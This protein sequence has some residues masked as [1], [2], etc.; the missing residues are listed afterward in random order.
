[1]NTNKIF[2][3]WNIGQINI[4][5]CSD[6]YRIHATLEECRRANLDVVCLQ[7]VRRLNTGAIKH[8]GYSF[9]WNGLKRL[10]KHGVAIA[11]RNSKD[12]VLNGVIYFSAR[13]MAAD[14]TVKGCRIRVVSCYAPTLN[15]SLAAKQQFYRDLKR[16][17]KVEK[18]RKLMVMGDF[19]AEPHFC[20]EHSC[21]DGRNNNI[22]AS[23]NH[24]N[25]NTM[26]FLQFCQNAK[27]SI[28]NTWFDHPIHHRITW[29]HPNSA[30]PGRVI[31]YS[32][33]ESWIRQFVTNVRVKNSYFN[34]D[35]KLLI[36]KMNTP[37]NKAA[38]RFLRKPKLKRRNIAALKCETISANVQN[39][40]QDHILNQPRTSSTLDG[41]HSYIIDSLAAGQTLIPTHPRH[42]SQVI[43]WNQD[44]QL[45]EL[46]KIRIDLRK[47][48]TTLHDRE[49]LKQINKSIK[50]RV[51]ELQNKELTEKGRNINEARQHRNMVKMWRNAKKHDAS[52]YSKAQTIPC[53]GLSEHFQQHFNPDHSTLAVPDEI[54]ET[55]QYIRILQNSNIE[56][57]DQTPSEEEITQAIK[58]LNNGKAA[59]DI[60][61]ELIKLAAGIPGFIAELHLYFTRIWT[62]KQV[63]KQWAISRICAIWKNKGSMT[64]P[65]KY[66]GISIGSTLCKVAMNIILKR[67]SDF[68]EQQLMRTQFGFR[69]GMGCNDGIYMLKQMQEVAETSDKKLYVCFVDL[70]AAFDHVNRDML[71]KTIKS[72]IHSNQNNANIQI[73]ENLYQVTKSYLQHEDPDC[74]FSTSSG[75]RQGGQEGPW[76][77]NFYHDFALRVYEDRKTANGIPGLEIPFYIPNEATNR[78]QRSESPQTGIVDDDH[79]GYADDSAFITWSANDL[80]L[81]MNILHQVFSE[82]G[83]T[84]NLEKTETMIFNW[85]PSVDGVYPNSIITLNNQNI[86]NSTSFKYLGVW[87]TGNCLHIG[88]QELNHRIDSAHCAFAQSRKLLTNFKI[89]LSTRMLFLNSLVRSCLTY[90]CHCWKPSSQE[91]S[92]IESTYRY[93]MRCMVFNGHKRVNPPSDR[94]SD[95]DQD[96]EEDDVDWRYVI[97]NENLY[98]I[99]QSS[100]IQSFYEQQQRNWMSHVIRRPNNNICKALTFHSTRRVRLGRKPLSILDRAVQSSNTSQSEFLRSAFNRGNQGTPSSNLVG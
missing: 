49:N 97:N 74:S 8:L 93:F 28:L 39:A 76:L 4:Q 25:E 67:L 11:I 53:P 87:I 65:T 69:S 86:S 6:D 15:S 47:N 95:L 2:H 20:R 38:R 85:N 98:E 58:Q 42:R 52:L 24:A 22:D 46:H 96:I 55:P 45:S 29:H 80:Q 33:S 66:R 12:M 3:K 21:Y 40:I 26:L 77:F 78:Q 92:K 56:I 36:T 61:A 19:N 72:R 90:G 99:T 51:R 30:I 70:T 57:L 79:S 1:M 5:S 64:D 10:K 31:D 13:L 82:Y 60:E 83:L 63:P 88:N 59:I 17:C 100:T 71:F 7:E 43:P 14:L 32:L 54:S 84:I 68:Y 73:I 9:Y 23:S 16:I 44:Q 91:L 37:A 89:T 35:H 50:V 34:S 62:T 27:V 75:V 81:S 94:Q 41:S 18:P 48:Q